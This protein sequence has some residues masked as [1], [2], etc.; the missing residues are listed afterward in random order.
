MLVPVDPGEVSSAGLAHEFGV[1]RGFY[2]HC[3][4]MASGLAMACDCCGLG[5]QGLTRQQAWASVRA[6][7]NPSQA[8]GSQP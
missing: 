8:I 6:K 2:K 4:Q 1:G 3:M 5:E 7:Q